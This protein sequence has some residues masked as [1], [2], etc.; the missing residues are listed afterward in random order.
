MSY[1]EFDTQNWSRQ[2][3][4]HVFK[5][6]A[7][8]AFSITVEIDITA[9]LAWVKHHQHK[10]YPAMIHQVSTILNRHQEFK[11]AMKD[12]TLIVWNEIHPSYTIPHTEEES[13]SSI[14]SQHQS[15]IE[16]F[17]IEYEKD[18][19][20]YG[21]DLSYFP[22]GESPENIFYISALPWISFTNFSMQFASL[23]NF[24]TPTVTL[25]KYFER[26]HKTY[27]P[28]AIQLHHAVCDGFHAGRFMNELQELCSQY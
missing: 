24:F 13:F 18:T 12:E 20:K 14:W 26:D 5:T 15:R 10:F 3:H 9:F 11:M 27:I 25:G 8:C 19:T 1:I 2:E 23:H 28:V 22:R 21:T 4:F 7:Q 17:M 6:Y 16:D